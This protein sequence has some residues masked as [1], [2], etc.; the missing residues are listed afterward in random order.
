VATVIQKHWL[1]SLILVAGFAADQISKALIIRY[2][3]FRTSWPVEGFFRFTHVGNRGSAFGLIDD[4]NLMLIIVSFVGV[5]ILLYFYRA[6]T[7]PTLAVQASLGLMLA[8]ALG[9]LVDRVANGHVTDFIDIGPWWIFNLADSSIVIG[10]TLLAS[11]VVLGSSKSDESVDDASAEP[12]REP[13][14][15]EPD[16][17]QRD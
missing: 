5:G 7:D 10:I 17:E 4:A 8:G 14:R 16:D 15:E 12:V 6:Q 3:P 1:V 9:N 13:T 11:S 2:V